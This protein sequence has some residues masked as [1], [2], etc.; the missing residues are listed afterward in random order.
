MRY[1]FLLFWRLWV[2]GQRA[3]VVQAQRHIHSRVA[4]RTGD[5]VAP[6]RHRRTAVQR[7]VG[8]DAVVEGDPLAD[9]GLGL[10][11]VDVA[12]ETNTTES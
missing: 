5:R 1:T 2:C 11:P 3:S 12:L 7:L 9:A 10:S 8:P 6:Y 4:E